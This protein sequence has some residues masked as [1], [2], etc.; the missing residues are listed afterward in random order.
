MHMLKEEQSNSSEWGMGNQGGLRGR[1][2]PAL[3]LGFWLLTPVRCLPRRSADVSK[4]WL[5]GSIRRYAQDAVIARVL[6][7]R[8][9]WGTNWQGL[10]GPGP[11][12][13][14]TPRTPPPGPSC[15]LSPSWWRPGERVPRLAAMQA[16]KQPGAPHTQPLLSEWL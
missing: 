8:W 13:A 3:G 4:G 9:P 16:Q 6:W 11:H 12:R 2:V 10:E 14:D 7:P 1:R 5:S 15:W